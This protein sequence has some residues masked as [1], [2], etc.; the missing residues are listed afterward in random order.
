MNTFV[1]GTFS[2]SSITSTIG[3]SF[4]T[5]RVV[6]VDTGTTVYL[7]IWDTAG[8]ERFRSITKLYY[9]GASAVLL[10]YSIID[11]S[12]FEEMGRWLTEMREN[13]GNDIIIHVIGTKSDVV[14][15]EPNSRKVPFERCIAYVADNLYPQK[16]LTPTVP[17]G[18]TRSSGFW[19]Q[20]IGT[21]L[22]TDDSPVR[23]SPR[24]PRQPLRVLPTLSFDPLSIS[25]KKH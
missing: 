20:E 1:K 23:I 24:S 2:P 22:Q 12:S 10:V 8:Q 18:S 21:S 15:Q 4:L 13:L 3:A 17:S 19:G 7:Q 6:D 14:A 25:R 11:E 5:K 16:A 9:R